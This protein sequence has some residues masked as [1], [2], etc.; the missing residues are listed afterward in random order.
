M[1]PTKRNFL[2]GGLV[3]IVATILQL[4]PK[5]SC[6]DSSAK[7]LILIDQTDALSDKTLEAI[8]NHAKSA[9][10]TSLPYTNV[11]VKYISDGTIKKR[12]E[13]C[14]PEKI[15]WYTQ[16][17]A[18]DA[19]LTK[20]WK[21]FTQEFL[22]HLTSIVGVSE[23]SPIYETVIDDARLEFVDFKYKNLMVFTDFRQF[24]KNKINLQTK[25][26]DVSLETKNIL[27]TLPTLTQIDSSNMRPLN[28]VHVKRFFIPRADM[29][30]ENI[31][32]LTSVADMVFQNLATETTELTPI[33]FLPTSTK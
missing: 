16:I 19:T 13:G 23:S 14:R 11:V 17:T 29:T 8:Q 15:E 20:K 6:E 12:Y 1:N 7:L 26:G 27:D 33:E 5:H 28:G 9:I 31:S 2:I 24:T 21:E 30:K 22:G 3:I 10:D 4:I 25:C 32:C 18:D